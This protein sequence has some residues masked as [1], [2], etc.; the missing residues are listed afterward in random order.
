MLFYRT[1]QEM[2]NE[3]SF[4]ND[5]DLINNVVIENTYKFN[6]ACEK[7]KIGVDGL[8]TPTIPGSDEKFNEIV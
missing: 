2:I 8:Y 6:D 1:T 7:V 5:Q 3:F 4:L